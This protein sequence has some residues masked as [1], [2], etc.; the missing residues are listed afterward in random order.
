M[1]KNTNIVLV[2]VDELD[3][4]S[5]EKKTWVTHFQY[6][7]STLL[8]QIL[9]QKPS[10]HTITPSSVDLGRKVDQAAAFIAIINEQY[11]RSDVLLEL[12][13]RFEQ[14]MKDKKMLY[15]EGR[16]S[17]FKIM[18]SSIRTPRAV[19]F[20]S[21]ILPYNFYDKDP[22]TAKLRVFN[23]RTGSPTQRAYWLKL[24]DICYDLSY[25]LRRFSGEIEERYTKRRTVHLAAV[26]SDMITTRDMVRRELLQRSYRVLPE[27]SLPPQVSDIE[28]ATSEDLGRSVLSIH[29]VGEDYGQLLPG[30]EMSLVAFQNK[31]AHAHTLSV[32]EQRKHNKKVPSFHRLIWLD[33]S[34]ENVSETQQIFIEDLKSEAATIEEAEVMEVS[35]EEFKLIVRNNLAKQQAVSYSSSEE[36]SDLHSYVYLMHDER[37]QEFVAPLAGMLIDEGLEVMVLSNEGSPAELRYEHQDYLRRCHGSI[38]Y[39]KEASM[40]WFSSRLQDLF[41]APAFGRK[42]PIRAKAA[43]FERQVDFD[44]T[45]L[46]KHIAVLNGGGG[47]SLDILRPFIRA[48]KKI[49]V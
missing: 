25:V 37:D 4:V 29:L 43:V 44:L 5:E 31:I 14:R 8:S 9:G 7:L 36:D 15:V 48:I 11:F 3:E 38:I 45:P 6:F 24:S 49:S 33:P 34:I 2:H 35:I 23:P 10:I 19:S 30:E 22:L 42:Q 47:I 16:C 27:R 18:Q 1:L 32:L 13:N 39:V 17:F 20:M 40:Q 46:K 26:G 12:S 21:P 41:K 28:R